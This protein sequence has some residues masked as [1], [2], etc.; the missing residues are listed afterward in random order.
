MSEQRDAEVHHLIGGKLCL[1]F[2]NTL[3][4]HAESV[5]EYLYDYRDLVLWS[6]HVGVL[7]AE[8]AETLLAMGEQA[9]AESE[10]V[11]R[12]A[13]Q[14]RET[15]FHVFASLAQNVS[16]PEKELVSL[17]QVWLEN[18]SHSRLKSTET[19]FALRWEEG[20]ALDAMLWPITRSA[21]ELL[22]SDDLDRVKQCGRCDWLFLDKSRN[23]S[24]RWCSMDAC[25]NRI[26][27][28]R[29][30]EREKQGT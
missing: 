3:Y 27:M 20:D 2:S 24:R 6:R 26:K 8:K 16:P 12:Q 18:Q 23:R 28:A 21:M 19:G 9:Q 11:F 4:G 14:I 15:I 13:I 17:H 10:A 5:H 1:D 29:R 25:G 22:I 30:Y 7:S